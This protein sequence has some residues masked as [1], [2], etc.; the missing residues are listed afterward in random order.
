L[1]WG[2]PTRF[3]KSGYDMP[4]YQALTLEG[5]IHYWYH[6]CLSMP[7]YTRAIRCMDRVLVVSAY[8]QE[9]LLR[10]GVESV[11]IPNATVLPEPVPL[12][13]ES[14]V[15]LY[16]GRLERLKGVQYLLQAFVQVREKV[17][18]ARLVVAGTGNYHAVLEELSGALGLSDVVEWK[19]HVS[20]AV[21]RELYAES[22][23]VVVPSVWP[24]PFGKVGIEAMGVGRPVV[25]SDVGG[26]REWLE[27]GVTGYVVPPA[28]PACLADKLCIILG[29][30]AVRERMAKNAQLRAQ[31][32]SLD[33]FMEA[34]MHLHQVCI[35]THTTR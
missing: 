9:M 33:V 27:D 34:L 23:V 35:E 17:P 19:G 12:R 13:R 18:S 22:A 16:A 4:S 30:E 21:L 24:E 1:L 29:D 31:K 5:K 7:V 3:F 2:F 8:M 28:D 25:A 6:H 15:V 14:S 26:I 32:F 20:Q 11:C 10:E